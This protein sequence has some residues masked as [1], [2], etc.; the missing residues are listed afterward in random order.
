MRLKVGGLAGR[1]ALAALAVVALGT[2][3]EARAQDYR[4]EVPD[5]RGMRWYK[6]NTHT[7]TLE[8]DGDSPA[9]YVAR[10]YKEHGYNF[11]VLSDHDVLT[12]PAT[13]A[14][15]VDSTFILIPGEE[16]SASFQGV[17]VHVNGLNIP[18]VVEPREGPTLVATLQNNIGAV[19]EVGGVPHVNHPNYQWA[20]RAED[21]AQVSD[22]RLVEIS[23]GHPTVHN[24]GGGDSPGAEAIWDQL[25]S[26]GKRIY[27]IAADDAHY[28]QGEFGP[29][30]V[31]PGRGWVVVRARSLD[32]EEIM[33]SLEDGLFYAS[34][35]VELAD[36]VVTATRLSVHIRQ[37]GNFKYTTTFIGSA[38][39][40]LKE[41]GGNPAVFELDGP[42]GYVR[43]RVRDSGGWFAWTQPVFVTQTSLP[44]G[45][46][47]IDSL[48]VGL[49]SGVRVYAG[50]NDAL[51]LRAW[52]VRIDEPD[53]TIITRI[54][55]SDDTTDN[56]E[57]TSS[58]ARD[59]GACVAVNGGYFTMNRTPA[60][61]VG[62]LLSDGVLWE[63]A[64][65][66]VMRDTLRFEIARA[67]IG[68]TADDEI[69][70]TWATTRDGTIYA[71][72]DP[73]AHRPGEL[74]EPLDY[75]HA[76][77]WE[78]RDAIGA[79]PALVMDGRI[80]VTSE[81]E[82][83]F[84]TSIPQVHPRTAA[85]RTA[86][87]AL[88]LMV[89][90]GRQPESRGVSLDELAT[91]MLEV[92]AVEAINLDGGG[93]SSLVVNGVLVNRPQGRTEEREVMSALVTY[94]Q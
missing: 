32:A 10:W 86:D 8:S 74:A 65:R 71:W 68:F 47:P 2:S 37:R 73:P 94:C 63:P 5:V 54:V 33:Q 7:H 49:P 13:V 41:T 27:G 20:L 12:D 67:A 62:L 24:F 31:N 6:G 36:V 84:G 19:R 44:M 40:V 18:R 42:T 1:C 66:S 78:V 30:R 80:R 25:L 23:N 69:E 50:A 53:P 16:V 77:A 48:N 17:S 85:G 38:G 79:G 83:F 39:K 81:E 4:F 55:V 51:P 9:E 76:R 89:V 61:H 11:L 21:L 45:W 70:F 14:H 34:T 58:F 22:Y 87:G 15:L 26:G 88:I 92:G 72:A 57:T 60:G 3:T 82:V 91:L 90:D 93:S 64:T 35:G 59:L 28:F 75:E 56:R 46:K 52:Y 29:R 43:A